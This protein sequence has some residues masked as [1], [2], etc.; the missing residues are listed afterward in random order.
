[1]APLQFLTSIGFFLSILFPS[2]HALEVP[3]D[4]H[5][6]HTITS[7]VSC[8][9]ITTTT[10]SAS[11]PAP[12]PWPCPAPDCIYLSSLTIPCGCPTKV[13]T[14]S[15]YTPCPK[16]CNG[17]CA[18]QYVTAVE[19]RCSTTGTSKSSSR[20]SSKSSSKSTLSPTILPPLPPYTP[21][22]TTTTTYT[23]IKPPTTTYTLIKPSTT[24][25]PQPDYCATITASEGPACWTAGC[26]V[27]YS[28]CARASDVTLSCGCETIRTVTAC[29]RSC[30]GGCWTNW[31][32]KY[33]PCP[34]TPSVSWETR[35][36]G[37]LTVPTL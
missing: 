3:V 34:M 16:G 7:L 15:V 32:T 19:S 24:A 36:G 29:A 26:P 37:V 27:T 18:T 33:L 6:T 21:P 20:T 1:M 22:G 31:A 5:P 35:T 9:T 14:A 25:K 17:A 13:A 28:R 12:T 2:I 8:P 10:D 4:L 11:C 30:D 23:P